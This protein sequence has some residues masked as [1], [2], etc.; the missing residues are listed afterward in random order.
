[1]P[2]TEDGMSIRFVKARKVEMIGGK[3]DA[4]RKP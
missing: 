3:E 2:N 1:M 4:G